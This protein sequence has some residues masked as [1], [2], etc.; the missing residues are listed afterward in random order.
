LCAPLIGITAP[1]TGA[2]KSNIDSLSALNLYAL[3]VESA[4]GLP[5]FFP[6]CL[7]KS[8]LQELFN[9]IDGIIFSGGGDVHPHFYNTA[10]TSRLIGVDEQRDKIELTLA[11]WVVECGK[12]FLG[13]CRGLQV[14]NVAHGGSLHQ[15]L[16]VDLPKALHHD[17]NVILEG[18]LSHTVTL[19]PE[20]LLFHL[21][22]IQEIE[23]NSYHHQAIKDLAPL[24]KVS[25]RALD[26]VIEAVE[27]PAHMFGIGVQWHPERLPDLPETNSLLVGLTEAACQ[28]R[29]QRKAR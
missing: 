3:L 16:L 19:N 18:K 23:V 22:G 17:D 20:S 25:G 27:V 2:T 9:R 26:G 11:H 10:Q 28:W 12:P 24:L 13:I 15:D 5:I 21:I 6:T 1:R 29:T 7:S 14:I 4:G 8:S